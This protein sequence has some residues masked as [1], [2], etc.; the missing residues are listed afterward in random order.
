MS[1]V[2]H[3]S[4]DDAATAISRDFALR[5]ECNVLRY[6]SLFYNAADRVMPAPSRPILNKTRADVFLASRLKMIELDKGEL[7][8][9]NVLPKDLSRR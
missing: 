9:T 2:L 8:D 6:I 5:I 4:L 7:T 1:E 3:L